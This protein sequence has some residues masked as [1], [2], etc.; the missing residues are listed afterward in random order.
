MCEKYEDFYQAGELE[1]E[2]WRQLRQRGWTV[3]TVESCTGGAVAAK[4]VNVAGASEI[5]RQA[6]VTY[7]DEAKNRLA[8]VGR[9]TLEKYTAVS[10]ETAAEM[11][12]GG[13]EAAEADLA[14]SVTGLAGPGGGTEEKPVGLVYVGCAVHGE[15]QVRELHLQGSRARIREQAVS[16]ALS[17]A[18]ET[19]LAHHLD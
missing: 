13:A 5:L 9:N 19:L 4:I 15:T 12:L 14:I 8:G 7:C 17:L 10:R 6:Y 2:L 3:T 16:A 11:A 1:T 18:L